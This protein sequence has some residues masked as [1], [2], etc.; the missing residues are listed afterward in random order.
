MLSIQW[1]NKANVLT[2]QIGDHTVTITETSKTKKSAFAS[3]T[4]TVFVLKLPLGVER[5]FSSVEQA[6]T[7]AN[8]IMPDS[9]NIKSETPTKKTKGK[10]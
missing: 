6:Q 10:K 8:L 9:I 7:Y 1:R 3:S 2:G 5:S 4:R